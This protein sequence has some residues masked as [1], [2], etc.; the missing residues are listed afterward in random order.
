MNRTI[1]FCLLIMAILVSTFC[2]KREDKQKMLLKC[3]CAGYLAPSDTV[4]CS[5]TLC[6]SDTC[7][8]YFAIWKDLLLSRNQMSPD[9]FDNHITPCST[10]IDR[11]ND[12]ISFRIYYKVK[13][14]WAEILMGDQFIIWLSSSTSGLY[15][16]LPL[17]RDTLLTKEQINTAFSLMAF[18]SG[19]NV[20]S[21]INVLRYH[22]FT[23]AMN[24]VARGS[25]VDTLCTG[26]LYYDPP[27]L[28]PA[29]SGQPYLRANGIL[30]W[31][32]NKCITGLL[33]L[34]TG[35]VKTIFDQCV[36]YFCVTK[37]TLVT[38]NNTSTQPIEK[39]KTG[40]TIL[41][42]NT[43]SMKIEKDLVVK[44][45]S[46]T[47]KDIIEI[48]FSDNKKLSSTCDHPFYVKGKGWCSYKPPETSQKYGLKAKQLKIGDTCLEYHENTLIEVQI[49]SISENTREV[50]T[51]NISRLKNNKNYFA[52]GILVSTEE[53]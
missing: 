16:S 24:A 19:M 17:P 13:I 18:S 32:E 34:Y 7:Q 15:P 23:E 14:E 44:I 43:N 45:D 22:S 6:Q 42:V 30:N 5:G 53:N 3:D 38:K 47:H 10:S 37:G 28:D 52:N 12:G 41:S 25:G 27:H 26:D 49:N 51:Y 46:V 21:S 8:N 35:E 2:T 9:Y 39:I 31:N 36:I 11:W 1:P 40:D 29:P 50:K 48:K 4:A 20:I 33:N